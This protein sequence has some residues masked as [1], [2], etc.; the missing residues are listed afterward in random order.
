MRDQEQKP[1]KY[2]GGY[3]DRDTY[4]AGTLTMSWIDCGDVDKARRFARFA[5]GTYFRNGNLDKRRERWST[6]HDA[7]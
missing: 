1:V 2:L 4:H 5:A 6:N 3:T 7:L